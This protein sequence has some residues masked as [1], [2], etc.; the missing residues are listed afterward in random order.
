MSG[1][2][3]ASFVIC[4]AAIAWAIQDLR[5]EVRLIRERLRRLEEHDGLAADA[6]DQ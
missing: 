5:E 3:V 1:W 2:V 6:D 4:V